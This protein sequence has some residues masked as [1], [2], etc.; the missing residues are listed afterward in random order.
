MG[1]PNKLIDYPLTLGVPLDGAVC[2]S[3][4]FENNLETK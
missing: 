4:T 1:L 2:F 3:H